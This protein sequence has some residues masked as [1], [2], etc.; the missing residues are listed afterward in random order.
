MVPVPK[1]KEPLTKR[2]LH[3]GLTAAIILLLIVTFTVLWKRPPLLLYIQLTTPH[4][5]P[6]RLSGRAFNYLSGRRL[7]EKTEHLDALFIGGREPFLFIRFKTD[8]VGIERIIEQFGGQG[9]DVSS[10]LNPR[11]LAV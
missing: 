11:P 9:A 1:R 8:S 6:A 3:I 4:R 2:K 5:L 7:P 10:P